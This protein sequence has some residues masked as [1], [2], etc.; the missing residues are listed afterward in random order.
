MGNRGSRCGR[1]R[2]RYDIGIGYQCRRSYS[3]DK[4]KH[5]R[6]NNC[7]ES[8]LDGHGSQSL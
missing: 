5:D 1:Q 6:R 8:G 4:C 7:L 2:S 3:P